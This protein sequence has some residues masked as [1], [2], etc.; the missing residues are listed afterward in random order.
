MV[1]VDLTLVLGGTRSGKSV[2]AETLVHKTQSLVYVAPM[3]AGTQ[4]V[5]F[6][7]RVIV[8]RRRR[9][10]T[11]STYEADSLD[12]LVTFLTSASTPVLV[13]SLGSLVARVIV[14]ETRRPK[15]YLDNFVSALANCKSSVVVSEEVGLAIHPTSSMGRV[16]VDLLGEL[17]QR[18]AAIAN[19]VVFV[20]AG[21]PLWIK[22]EQRSS[23]G[24]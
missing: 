20:V 13:D 18:V 9:P 1:V 14:E 17:N 12:D 6:Q 7:D 23:Y 11:W 10:A 8:H 22:G 5:E 21:I 3:L 16:Y 4:D 2:F 24:A 15:D 19:N